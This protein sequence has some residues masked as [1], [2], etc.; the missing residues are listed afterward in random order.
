[1][2]STL[3]IATLVMTFVASLCTFVTW[4]AYFVSEN[5]AAFRGGFVGVC[6][7]S[8]PLVYKFVKEEF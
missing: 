4:D 3:I 1:M 5:F 7:L 8:A 2:F 6:V